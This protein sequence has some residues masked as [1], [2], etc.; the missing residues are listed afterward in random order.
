MDG[1]QLVSMVVYVA[2]G[3]EGFVIVVL[4]ALYSAVVRKEVLLKFLKH[5]DVEENAI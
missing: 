5:A 1:E 4:Q 2:M 3:V